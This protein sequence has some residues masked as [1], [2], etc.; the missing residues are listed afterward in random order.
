MVPTNIND[1]AREA[2]DMVNYVQ[3]DMDVERGDNLMQEPAE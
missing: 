3:R 2:A 1:L